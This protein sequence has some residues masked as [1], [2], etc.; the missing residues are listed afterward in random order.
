MSSNVDFDF[1][2]KVFKILLDNSVLGPSS[3]WAKNNAKQELEYLLRWECCRISST[4]DDLRNFDVEE[5]EGLEEQ[6]DELE[7]E[8]S[9]LEDKVE[10]LEDDKFDLESK[11]ESY[12]IIF[13]KLSA[14]VQEVSVDVNKS[15][16]DQSQLAVISSLVHKLELIKLCLDNRRYDMQ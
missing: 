12:N 6:V 7:T 5:T 1:I 11:L 8:V 14:K 9:D 10:E 15:I 2:N 13:D 3:D 16:T 4:I